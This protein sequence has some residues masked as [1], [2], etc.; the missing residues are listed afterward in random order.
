MQN[1]ITFPLTFGNFRVCQ[2][3]VICAGAWVCPQQHKWY[4]TLELADG[5]RAGPSHYYPSIHRPL[6]GRALL[7]FLTGPSILTAHAPLTSLTVSALSERKSEDLSGLRILVFSRGLRILGF[8]RRS[9]D[10]GLF[11]TSLCLSACG[12]QSL[13]DPL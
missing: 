12:L 9:E 7:D 13:P 3:M 5:P 6:P 4:G 11:P 10:S 1:Q 2:S 8:F